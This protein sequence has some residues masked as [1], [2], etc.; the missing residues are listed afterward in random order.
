MNSKLLAE[1]APDPAPLQELIRQNVDD[2][3]LREIAAA[4]YGEDVELHYKGVQGFYAGEIPDPFHWHPREVL[5]L[6]QWSQPEDRSWSPG[7]FGERGHWMRIFCCASLLRAG[8][9]S[10]NNVG[11]SSPIILLVDSALKIRNELLPAVLYFLI[12]KLN[13]YPKHDY[14]RQ[15][16][17]I[18]CLL[19]IVTLNKCTE[20]ILDEILEVVTEPSHYQ[21]D[22]IADAISDCF[23][24]QTWK[25]ITRRLLIDND[26]IQ[27][28]DL[29]ILVS[30][31]AKDL[32]GER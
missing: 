24:S 13:L 17:A 25:N 19:M 2:A 18:G 27:P 15:Y 6:V 30:L 14:E 3:M 20:R 16:C 22:G 10:S 23:L 28:D 9:I 29:R 1:F 12:W 8:T 4:D 5:E 21:A 31:F 32:L 11:E 7:G 26:N